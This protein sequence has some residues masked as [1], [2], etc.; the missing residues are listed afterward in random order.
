MFKKYY[1]FSLASFLLIP[2]VVIMGSGV[3]IF[4][5]PEIA[6]RHANYERNYQLLSLLKQMILLAT[7]L[8]AIGM[9]LL[10]CFLLVKSSGQ[11]YWWLLLALLGPFGLIGLTMLSD[12]SPAA[13]DFHQ[14]FIQRQKSFLRTL[15]ETVFYA[16][17]WVVAFFSMLLKRDLMITFQAASTGMTRSQIIDQQNASS[18]MWAFAEGLEVLYFA[19]CFA[20]PRPLIFNL[21]ARLPKLREHFHER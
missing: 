8:L 2:P 13:R 19:M 12:R 14:Q 20:L 11:T 10:T 9:W 1:L 3:S 16:G 5:N 21:V 18:G 7:L 4:I 17:V 6:A 15:Y